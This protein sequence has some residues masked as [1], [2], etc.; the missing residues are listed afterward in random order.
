M[1]FRSAKKIILQKIDDDNH[2][3]PIHYAVRSNNRFI[4]KELLGEKYQCS[5]NGVIRLAGTSSMPSFPDVNLLGRDGL[6]PLHLAACSPEIE[7][8]LEPPQTNEVGK[9]LTIIE[10]NYCFMF[11][12]MAFVGI[13]SCP[14]TR[15]QQDSHQYYR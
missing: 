8:E 11:F 3:A 5:K 10:K 2:Y 15:P 12:S 9:K 1:Q 7:E 6:T 14:I 13:H 4:C